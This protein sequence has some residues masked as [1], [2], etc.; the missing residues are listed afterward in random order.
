MDS[1]RGERRGKR[2]GKE[3]GEGKEI[4]VQIPVMH[5]FLLFI[6]FYLILYLLS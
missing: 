3:G 6:S 5:Y 4:Q 2:R 1:K